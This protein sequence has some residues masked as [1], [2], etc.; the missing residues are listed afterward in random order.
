M[1]LS[2]S[3]VEVGKILPLRCTC[4]NTFTCPDCVYECELCAD[5]RDVE[6]FYECHCKG[7]FT[8]EGH[9]A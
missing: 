3:R 8:C 4:P 1:A 5:E 6:Y 7:Y 9:R 2:T